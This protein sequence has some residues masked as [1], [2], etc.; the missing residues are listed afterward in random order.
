MS[1]S[2]VGGI[3]IKPRNVLIVTG[4]NVRYA[5]ITATDSQPAFNHTTTIGA[6]ARTGTVCEATTNGIRPRSNQTECAS[7]TANTKPTT[8]PRANPIT[9]SRKVNRAEFNRI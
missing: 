7:S 2:A 8:A 3:D 5:E 4:K 9:A 1:S 6:I